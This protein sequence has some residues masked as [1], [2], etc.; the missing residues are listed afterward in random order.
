MEDPSGSDLDPA[1]ILDAAEDLRSTF[2]DLDRGLRV[3]PSEFLRVNAELTTFIAGAGIS[4][5]DTVL[6]ALGNGPLF[7]AALFAVLRRGGCPMLLHAETP[8]GELEGIASRSA[9]GLA[10]VDGDRWSSS[11]IP[12]SRPFA[13]SAWASGAAISLEPEAKE[14]PFGFIGVPLHPT[15]GT[16]GRPRVAARPGAAAIAEA[17][18]YV[19]SLDLGSADVVLAAVPMSHAYGYG[20]CVMTPLLCGATVVSMRRF[21]AQVAL[22]ALTGSGVTVYP[23]SPAALDLVL[24]EGAS[25]STLPPACR[26]LSAGAPLPQR[27][28]SDVRRH[29]GIVV[30]PSYGSTETGVITMGDGLDEPSEPSFVGAPI[31][32]VEVKIIPDSEA[33]DL[34]E[35][36]GRVLIRSPSMMAGYVDD[37]VLD[38]SSLS[39]DW[40]DTADLGSI[41]VHGGL[42]LHGRSSEAVNVYGLKVLP[43]EV[44]EVIKQLPQVADVKVYAH[45]GSDVLRAAVS[46][47]SELSEGDIRRHCIQHLAPYKRPAEIVFV[48]ALPRSPSGKIRIDELP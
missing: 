7:I 40:F 29:L 20:S 33:V 48:D 45:K 43:L 8:L 12:R 30:R 41:D 24:R 42:H 44:E 38:R 14:S 28:I 2:V 17:R 47:V 4:L 6:L 36:V 5:G 46:L 1:P 18:H 37:L 3:G 16:T 11:T 13:L 23:A 15:S 26:I 35:G 9:A 27:T 19:E 22:D 25:P 10:L 32:G 21:N 31:S 39:G 34:E